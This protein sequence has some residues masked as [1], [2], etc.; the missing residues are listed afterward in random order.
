MK[1]KFK[2]GFKKKTINET[3]EILNKSIKK[4]INTPNKIFIVIQAIDPDNN[5]KKIINAVEIDQLQLN[6]LLENLQTKIE[7]LFQK[8][9]NRKTC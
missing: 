8:Y 1:P 7:V 5:N 9:N 3:I 2:R 6:K 4:K